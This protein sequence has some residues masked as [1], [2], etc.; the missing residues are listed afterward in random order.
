MDTRFQVPV[1]WSAVRED[2]AVTT[3]EGDVGAE[4]ESEHPAKRDTMTPNAD[5]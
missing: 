1:S 4:D 3:A 5:K 2:A